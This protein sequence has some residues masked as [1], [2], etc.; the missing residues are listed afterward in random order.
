MTYRPH[1]KHL[2]SPREMSVSFWRFFGFA[3]ARS[4]TSWPPSRLDRRRQLESGLPAKWR[5]IVA[6]GSQA[7]M[8][9]ARVVGSEMAPQ[10][11]EIARNG[12]ANGDPPI[13]RE[14]R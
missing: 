12:R 3:Q 7:A 14:G 1:A 9:F 10:A 11:I 2:V 8:A 4:E 5:G 6:T 13:R